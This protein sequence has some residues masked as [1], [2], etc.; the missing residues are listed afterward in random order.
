MDLASGQ[1]NPE[2]RGLFQGNSKQGQETGRG[3]TNGKQRVGPRSCGLEP[4]PAALCG[5]RVARDR[6]AEDAAGWWGDGC[7]WVWDSGARD[8]GLH[9]A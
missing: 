1:V 9:D 3:G 8:R 6:G 4:G 7:G 5:L 2:K